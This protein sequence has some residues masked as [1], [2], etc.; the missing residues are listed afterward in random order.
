MSELRARI[1]REMQKFPE[2]RGALLAALH[3]VH[4]E[5]GHV[6]RDV[7]VDRA[8]LFD[9]RPGEIAEVVSFYNMFHARPRARHE[10]R[11]CTN[12]S[13]SLRGARALLRELEAHLGLPGGGATEDGRIDLGHEECLG[14]C[15]W[16]PVV[17]VGDTYHENLDAEAAKRILDGRA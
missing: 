10:V 5:S 17:R 15:A 4:E 12:L 11:V 2:P 16:A 7:A 8:E 13:C 14:A 1:E 3:F 9:M 6:D